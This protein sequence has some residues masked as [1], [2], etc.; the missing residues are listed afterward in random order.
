[1]QLV[2]GGSVKDLLDREGRLP[3]GNALELT[4]QAA[5]GL[6]VAH[7]CGV[8][9]RD[10]KPSN[11]LLDRRGGLKIGDFGLAKPALGASE[12][13]RTGS[14]VGTPLYMSPEQCKGAALDARTDLYSLG[15][16]LFE[17]LLGKRPF[18]GET[19]LAVLHKHVHEPVPSALRADPAVPAP[20]ASLVERLM[21]KEPGERC[22]SAGELVDELERLLGR[23]A[24]PARTP[25]FDDR[26]SLAVAEAAIAVIRTRCRKFRDDDAVWEAFTA[27]RGLGEREYLQRIRAGGKFIFYS[28]LHDLYGFAEEVCGQPVARA[29]GAE[30]TD[31]VLQRHMPDILQSTLARAGTLADRLL[32]LIRQVVGATTGAIYELTIDVPPTHDLLSISLT[33]RSKEQTVEYLRR[34]GQ[35]PEEVFATSFAVFL[36]ALEALLA[37]VVHGFVPEQLKGELHP[38]RGTF[39]LLLTQENRFHYENFIDILLEYVRRLRERRKPAAGAAAPEA[40]LHASPAMRRAWERLRKAAA[41]EETVLLCGESGTGKSYYARVIHDLGPRRDGPFVEVGLTAEVGSDNLIQ[42]NL[43]GHVRGAFTGA[44]E[45]KQGLFAL[46]DGGSIFLDEIGDASPELQAKL[47]RVIEKKTFKMLGGVRDLSVNVRIIAA[48]NKDLSELVRQGRFREDLYYRLNVIQIHLPP[49]RERAEDLPALVQRLFERVCADARKPNTRLADTALGALRAHAWPG[50]I[51][52]LENALR[53]ALAFAEG[54]EIQPADLP[55]PLRA[56]AAEPAPARGTDEVIDPAALRHALSQPQAPGAP[57]HQW[58]GHIDH[59]KRTYL[60]ALIDR[61]HGEIA[62]IARHWDRSSENTLLKLIRELGLEE[63]L[64]AARR[65]RK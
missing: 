58:P 13:T 19:A 7:A 27:W 32:W 42:S 14:L 16:T 38:L 9:H 40:D 57:S 21:A 52:E 11:L 10:V 4:L 51:R 60:E 17:M 56:A 15:V 29:I 26:E 28:V 18:E 3:A 12:L 44:D 22:A 45:E 24:S 31:A 61:Y 20:V 63:H 43:F 49:L 50:N 46:A 53:H 1:M 39:R 23:R 25:V 62:Q 30:L 36:G 34:A 8:L 33:Y 6:E 59:A 2:D 47:L 5:R 65:A 64:H 48:T 55:E 54:P 35:D 41:S 37:R